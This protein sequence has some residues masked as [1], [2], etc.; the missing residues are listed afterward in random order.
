MNSSDATLFEAIWSELDGPP[1]P[2]VELSGTPCLPS[3][4]DVGSFATAT[5]AAATA[6]VET[7]RAVRHGGPARPVHVDRG[8]ASIAFR[9]E[10]YLSPQGWT[11]PPVWDP[12]AGDYQARDGWIRLHTNYQHHRDAVLRVLATDEK[13]DAVTSAVRAWSAEELEAAVVAEGGCAARM[14]TASEWAAHPQSAA[15]EREPLF[16]VTTRPAAPSLPGVAGAPLAGIRVLDLTRVMAGPVCT[17]LLAAYGADVLRIDPPGFDEVGALL[18][19]MT[20]GK[21]RALLDL[22]EPKSRAVFEGLL[23]RAH[24]VVHGYRSDALD[25]LGFGAARRRAINASLIDVAHDA[26]GWTGPWAHR[27]GFDS[28]V[29]MSVGIADAGRAATGADRP[30]PLPAQALDHACGYLL[31]AGACRALV[32]LLVERR[33]SDVRL[34]LARTAKLLVDQGAANTVVGTDPTPEAIDRY[35]EAV[36]TAWG[37]IRRIRCPARIADVFPR[38]AIAPGPLGSDA[39]AWP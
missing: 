2:P 10:R 30:F 20:A 4:Y 31:A 34:S 3:I 8:H 1:A 16:A 17:R 24:V 11:L 37:L 35:S 6:A 7:V 33:A 9:C 28:L 22:R 26:Y 15:L 19:E 14:R 27:R 32:R 13:R 39:P 25:R 23:A 5:I 38:L 29:Q 36:P 18:P 21:R 12:I